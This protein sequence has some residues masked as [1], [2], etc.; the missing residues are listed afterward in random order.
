M[1]PQRRPRLLFFLLVPV[2]APVIF[3]LLLEGLLRIAGIGAPELSTDPARG[4]LPFDSVFREVVAEDG[5]VELVVRTPPHELPFMTLRQFNPQSHPARKP[6]GEY[7]VLFVGGSLPY[8]WPYDDRTSFPRLLEVGLAAV[9]PEVGWRVIN[10]GAPGWGTTRLRGLAEDLTRLDPDLVVVVSGNNEALEAAFAKDALRGPEG[11][12]SAA[13][14]ALQTLPP[15]HADARCRRAAAGRSGIARPEARGPSLRRNAEPLWSRDS[16][17]ISPRSHPGSRAADRGSIS[18]PFPSTCAAVLHWGGTAPGSRVGPGIRR[19]RARYREAQQSA[20]SRAPCRGA[21]AGRG[22][23]RCASQQRAG[24]LPVGAGARRERNER[25]GGRR[26]PARPEPRPRHVPGVRRAQCPR[27]ARGSSDRGF[28]SGPGEAHRGGERT[29]G[30]G[31]R[32]VPRQLPSQPARRLHPRTGDRRGDGR[33]LPPRGGAGLA[34]RL[35]PRDRRLPG[36][37]SRSPTRAGWRRSSSSSST[38]GR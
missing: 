36:R 29:P 8:G 20:R 13:E 11:A 10:M 1:E 25:A 38:T 2:L 12:G 27:R 28:G 32:S 34:S 14:L 26:L 6:D 37:S 5:S 31:R 22:A 3:L 24:P 21:G 35:P 19:S 4:F 16:A 7:R 23:C 17:R 30:A 15:G 18:R 33:G 9:Q